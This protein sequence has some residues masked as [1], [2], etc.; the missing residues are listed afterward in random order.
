V[1]KLKQDKFGNIAEQYAIDV[2]AGNILACKFTI[3]ACQRHLDD[4]DRQGD[5]DF[6]YVFNPFIVDMEGVEYQPAER[7]CFFIELLPHVKGKWARQKLKIKLEPWQVFIEASVFGW[8][9]RETGIRRFKIAYVEIPRKNAKTT[10]ASGNGLYLLSRDNEVGAEVYSAATT[11]DQAKIS[12]QIAKS[13]VEK[14]PPMQSRFGVKTYAHSIAVESEG[15]FFQYLS[16]DS[17]GLD[18]LNISGA[19]IDELHA[20]K[21]REVFDVI[22]T[23]T[24]SREQPVIFIITTAGTNQAGICFEQ[25]LYTI[26]LI[27]KVL[28]DETY[29]GIIYTIDDDDDW[30]DESIHAKANPNFGVSVIPEDM[31]RLCDKAAAMPTATNNFLTKRLNVWCNADTSWLNMQKLFA[32]R[33]DTL[34]IDMFK[35]EPCFIGIDLASKIDIA[36]VMPLF[37]RMIDGKEHYYSFGRYYLPEETVYNSPNDSYQGWAN[38]GLINVT[39]GNIIDFA[40]IEDELRD[41]SENFEITEVPFDPFQAT[42]LSTRMLDEGFPMVMFG[43][44]VKNFSEPMKFLEAIIMDGRFHYGNDPVLEWAFSNVIAHVDKKDNIFPNKQRPENKIDPVVGLI[45]SLGR[46]ITGEI[47]GQSVYESRGLL[48]L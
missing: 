3:K 41:L 36:A 43:A 37:T 9:H 13:M 25:R 40:N 27:D 24:G 39:P 30:T 6:P 32:C 8:V 48:K 15:S 11:A 20:H 1:L 35:G 38:M 7:V 4:L 16:S 2:T 10:L 19:I 18:G 5:D 44:T 31:K 26:K 45:M 14:S 28:K 22:E 29:F 42:Q 34:T 21:T 17:K 23:G 47:V 12:W 33:D 46:C